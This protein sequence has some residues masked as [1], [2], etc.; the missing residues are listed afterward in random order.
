LYGLEKC[1]YEAGAAKK[2]LAKIQV[3]AYKL[4]EV[5]VPFVPGTD[6][7]DLIVFWPLFRPAIER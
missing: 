3:L 2:G 7:N 5:E 1:L 4:L 6:K